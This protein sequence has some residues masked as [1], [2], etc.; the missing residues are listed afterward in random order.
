MLLTC[1]CLY[2]I[3]SKLLDLLVSKTKMSIILSFSS[4]F[5]FMLKEITGG[6][7][8]GKVSTR[9]P[10]WYR[11]VTYV[12]IIQARPHEKVLTDGIQFC[13]DFK[14]CMLSQC[15]L[16]YDFN[17]VAVNIYRVDGLSIILI[18][19]FSRLTWVRIVRSLVPFLLQPLALWTRERRETEIGLR[20]SETSS[21]LPA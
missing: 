17:N 19:P 21:N 12:E 7:T 15:L 20:N 8:R 16:N 18:Q 1:L 14:Y 6:K 10:F 4:R 9:Y 3:S 2:Y 5:F 13:F 11:K